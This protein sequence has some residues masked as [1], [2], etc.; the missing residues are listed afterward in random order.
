[1]TEHARFAPPFAA[2]AAATTP[3][4]LQSAATLRRRRLTV[5]ALNV[6]TYAAL[7]GAMAAVVGAGGWTIVDLVLFA[8]FLVATPWTVLGFWNAAIG[9]WLLHGREPTASPRSRPSPARAIG[10]SDPAAHRRPDDLAQ[11]GPGAGVPAAADGESEH[12]GDRRGRSAS[13]ISS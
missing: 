7:A 4:G 2:A 3:A 9:L 5:L 10:R 6:A 1:M 11:R 8:C 13:P 12:R